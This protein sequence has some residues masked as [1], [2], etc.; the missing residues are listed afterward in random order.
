MK[1]TSTGFIIAIA[2]AALFYLSTRMMPGPV[3]PERAILPGE[4]ASPPVP[5]GHD[6]GAVN[7]PATVLWTKP[8]SLREYDTLILKEKNDPAAWAGGMDD[9]MRLWLVGKG[10]TMA[11]FGEPVKIM[12]RQGSWLKVA[13]S[14]QK[15]YLNENGY[16]GWVP[17][18]QIAANQLFLDEL[19]NLPQAVI[20]KKTTTLYREPALSNIYAELSYQTRLPILEE[21][22]QTVTVRLP[23]GEVGYLKKSDLKKAQELTF[24]PEGIVAEAKQFLGLPYIWGGTSSWGFD[25]SGFTMRL[26][27]S[28]GITIPRDADEQAKEGTAVAKEALQPG[29]LLFFAAQDGLGQIHHVGM[30]IGNGLMIHAPNSSSS[31]RVEAIDS[32]AYGEEYWGARRYVH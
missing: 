32:G 8:G 27:Q 2:V 28:Q 21:Q 26:Y 25:C 18:N 4:L 11:L 15:T 23:G 10:E 5:A 29:D 22:G 6:R 31:V 17:E 1:K 7:V 14:S 30:Y 13:A 19:K 16:L 20:V 12:E 3:T 24:S 9:S